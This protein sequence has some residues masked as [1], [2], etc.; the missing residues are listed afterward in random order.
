M[1]LSVGMT[2][3]DKVKHVI[4][5]EHSGEGEGGGGR[6]MKQYPPG[7]FSKHLLIKMQ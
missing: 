3:G 7:K 4:I 6:G 5:E 1:F 2:F